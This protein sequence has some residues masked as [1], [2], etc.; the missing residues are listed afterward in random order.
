MHRT[1]YVMLEELTTSD[2]QYDVFITDPSEDEHL[3]KG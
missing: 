1:V 3:N 2:T